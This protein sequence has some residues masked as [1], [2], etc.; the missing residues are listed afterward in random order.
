MVFPLDWARA[1]FNPF[2]LQDLSFRSSYLNMV[3]I[4]A[5]WLFMFYS[6]RVV[7]LDMV[8]FRCQMQPHSW[9][10]FWSFGERCSIIFSFFSFFVAGRACF[11][12]ERL[13]CLPVLMGFLQVLRILGNGPCDQV[14]LRLFWLLC[15]SFLMST[16]P[17]STAF[18]RAPN[19]MP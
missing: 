4:S 11:C 16:N 17:L 6:F 19:P 14:F 7:P 12:S 5:V 13:L 10:F 3:S 15:R 9:A 2:C 1:P 18:P 8:F